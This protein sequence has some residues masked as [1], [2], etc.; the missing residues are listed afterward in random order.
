MQ[1]R[2]RR[3][4]IEIVEES[5]N[6]VVRLAM[7]P[8]RVFV[9]VVLLVAHVAGLFA[10]TSLKALKSEAVP[11]AVS[12]RFIAEQ[13]AQQAWQPL[14]VST[15]PV[16]VDVQQPEIPVIETPVAAALDRAITVPVQSVQHAPDP[17][18]PKLVSVVEYLREPE[19]RYPPQSRRLREQG[20]VVLRVLIDER[21]QA[22][23]VN[24]ESS[25]GFVRLDHAARE[26]VQRATFRPYI[27]AGAPRRAMVLIPIEFALN[28]SQ[29]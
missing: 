11:V 7:K 17:S 4:I 23:E 6:Q 15:V 12:V 21:G 19:P 20:T 3:G 24:V 27:E 13:S 1:L 2:W 22:C 5:W 29:A 14:P 18:V 16:R 10:L 9:A 28:H 25:S 26:A 8:D